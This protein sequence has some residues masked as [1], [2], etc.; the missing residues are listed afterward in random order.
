MFTL[1]LKQTI[2]TGKRLIFSLLQE[3]VDCCLW[4]ICRVV[5][6]KPRLLSESCRPLRSCLDFS[7]SVYHK[8]KEKRPVYMGKWVLALDLYELVYVD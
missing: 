1:I 2:S 7:R 3:K 4:P 8:D 6:G 5:C